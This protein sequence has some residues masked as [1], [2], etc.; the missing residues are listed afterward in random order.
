MET[1]LETVAN[2]PEYKGQIYKV[3]GDRVEEMTEEEYQV[4]MENSCV[5][6]QLIEEA[7]AEKKQA[8][9][10]EIEPEIQ[11]DRPSFKFQEKVGNFYYEKPPKVI[12][13]A[14][15]GPAS[16]SVAESVSH[17]VQ[18]GF[19]VGGVPLNVI[20]KDLTG[21]VKFQ[22]SYTWGTTITHTVNIQEGRVGRLVYQPYMYYAKGTA[23]Y[24]YSS[25]GHQPTLICKKQENA[26]INFPVPNESGGKLDVIYY[27]AYGARMGDNLLRNPGFDQDFLYW[28]KWNGGNYD[29]SKVDEEGGHKRLRHT[30]SH[31]YQT[32][33]AQTLNPINPGRFKASVKVLARGH[34]NNLR[35]EVSGYGGQTLRQEF[36][37]ASNDWKVLEID[38][39]RITGPNKGI[40]IAVHSN[41]SAN[42]WAWF[43]DFELVQTAWQ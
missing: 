3:T 28:G 36:G 19:D 41:A 9:I 38:N 13:G 30:A 29:A 37:Q 4:A 34:H 33:T 10:E 8:Q 7:R 40:T 2:L 17:S 5:V 39:I 15:V 14:V 42:S 35:L 32:T 12:S 11:D 20:A 16:A 24:C 26:E 23:K 27:V 6:E 1:Q 43:D 31:N 25:G 22:Y 21:S 18:F